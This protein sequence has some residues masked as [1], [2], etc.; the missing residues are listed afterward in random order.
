MTTGN[1]WRESEVIAHLETKMMDG[2]STPAEDRLY[3]DYKW[4]G[5]IVRNYTYR[6]I[7]KEM[8]EIWE[9]KY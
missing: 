7:V 2:T 3:E 5:K 6:M 4:D 1:K 9:G 8:N